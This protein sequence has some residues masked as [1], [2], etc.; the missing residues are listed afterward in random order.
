MTFGPAADPA[1]EARLGVGSRHGGERP[2]FVHDFAEVRRPVALVV[3]RL[4]APTPTWMGPVARAAC[5]DAAAALAL[6]GVPGL[7]GGQDLDVRVE[8][9][10]P[11]VHGDTSIVGLRWTT[12]PEAALRDLDADL[13]VGPFGD[14]RTQLVLHGRCD[15]PAD[16]EVPEA[17]LRRAA[18]VG[19][20]AFLTGLAQALELEPPR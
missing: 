2:M 13:E 4:A 18:R 10:P 14:R 5:G 6:A 8:T 16:V 19:V 9:G 12:S 7:P 20:R 15:P 17:A 1:V 11:R 3:A